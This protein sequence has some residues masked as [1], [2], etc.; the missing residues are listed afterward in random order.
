MHGH[1]RHYTQLCPV[2]VH[3]KLNWYFVKVFVNMS[4]AM[5]TVFGSLKMPVVC[6]WDMTVVVRP[7]AK[8]V[9]P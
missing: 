1:F 2:V 3:S 4:G 6:T 9:L 7:I 5:D 8:W